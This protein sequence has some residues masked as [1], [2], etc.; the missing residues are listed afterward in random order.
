MPWKVA[1]FYYR[2]RCDHVMPTSSPD[3]LKPGDELSNS[4]EFR[5]VPWNSDHLSERAISSAAEV[6][7]MRRR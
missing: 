5:S 2:P 3:I 1:D 6:Q 7:G 4:V